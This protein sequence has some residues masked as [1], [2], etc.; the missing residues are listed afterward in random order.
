MLAS[1]ILPYNVKAYSEFYQDEFISSFT[2]SSLAVGQIDPGKGMLLVEELNKGAMRSVSCV[3][4]NPAMLSGNQL[5]GGACS[6]V[7]FRVAKEALALLS[8]FKSNTQLKPVSL[9]LS[10][11]TRFA[12]F[13]QN[14]EAM[15]IS[16]KALDKNQ[17]TAIRTEQFALNTIT[18]DREVV[19]AGNAVAEKMSAMAPFYGLRVVEST[20]EIIVH[21]NDQLEDQ[22]TKQIQKLTE[23][24]Y[25]LRIIQ[26]KYNH[27]L[28]EKGHSVVY[29]KSGE[30]EYVFD[31]AL[32]AYTLFAESTKKNLVYNALLSANQKFGVDVL[33]FHRLEEDQ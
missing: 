16:K 25:F 11:I 1:Q 30:V 22:L 9:Q 31:P 2:H 15:T 14:L 29:I 27:K 28:E 26:E 5:E 13:I 17:Q 33:S 10:F 20:P 21:G 8:H 12:R 19:Q 4:F 3:S 7:S 6:A 23:G 24:V 18:V 32:G